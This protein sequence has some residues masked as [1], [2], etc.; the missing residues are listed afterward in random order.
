M[1]LRDL[2][3]AVEGVRIDGD[4]GVA[5]GRIVDDSRACVAGDA[6]VALR[7]EHVDGHAFV[8]QAYERGAAAAVVE[9]ASAFP[10]DRAQVVVAD[11]RRAASRIAA[12]F[13]GEPSHTLRVVGITGTNGKTT[14]SYLVRAILEAA[15][16]PCAVVGTLGVDFSGAAS[17]LANTTPPAIELQGILANVRDRGARAVSMEVSSHALAL[18][19]IDDVRFDVAVLTNVTR[20][21][22]D[23]HGSQEAYVAAKRRLFDLARVAVLNADDPA[24]AAFA[25][26][27]R[28]LGREVITYAIDGDADV[29]AGALTLGPGGSAFTAAGQHV[30]LALPGRFNVANALAALGVARAFDVALPRAAAALGGV[31]SVPGRMER[32]SG[33]GIDVIVDYAH[34]PDAL[35]NVLRSVRES[36]RGR[37]VAVFG[38]GGDRDAGKR[39]EM[40]AVA[41]ALADAVIVTSDN[42]RGED[43]LAIAQAVAAPIGAPIVLDR[44]AA[45]RQAIERAG[46]GDVVV[47]AGKGHEPYQIVGDERRPFDDRDE[48][49]AALGAREVAAR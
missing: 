31:Q 30:E 9:R 47:V 25:R 36:T 37:L 10:A 3:G 48:V 44:R 39:P 8:G 33:G 32:F 12:R 21:H 35:A 24:G 28:A 38:C 20:D 22:L 11:S 1:I 6:F 27:L 40:G 16:E 45:I 23:F 17:P 15:G 13:Y 41:G 49:R 2:V 4:S 18:G 26:E 29:R 7:G 43:P 19:R 5:I 46:A 14:A 34:T 42:P